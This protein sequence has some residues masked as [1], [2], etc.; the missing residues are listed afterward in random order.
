MQIPL[1]CNDRLNIIKGRLENKMLRDQR[2]R[3]MYV[4]EGFT[5]EVPF[6]LLHLCLFQDVEIFTCEE[7]RDATPKIFTVQRSPDLYYFS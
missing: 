1:I 6:E 7:L 5:E 2:G 3:V 4:Q